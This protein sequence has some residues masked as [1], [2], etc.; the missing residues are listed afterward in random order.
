MS[1]PF[2]NFAVISGPDWT[3]VGTAVGTIA[4]AAM[5]FL[6][7]VTTIAITV[8]DR[9]RAE[10]R[11]EKERR[12]QQ[13][14][15]QLARAY[16][17]AFESSQVIGSSAG[18]LPSDS[19][20][21]VYAAKVMNGS[22][23]PIWNVVCMI[24]TDHPS[25]A[26]APLHTKLAARVGKFVDVGLGSAASAEQFIPFANGNTYRIK[27]LRSGHQGAFIW[28]FDIERYFNP[29]FSARFTDD[30]DRHW[31]IGSDLHLTDIESRD[32]W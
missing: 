23:R 17:V 26:S 12:Q 16:A 14:R 22:D 9:R 21:T 32:D 15:E 1:Q 2:V 25:F 4:L 30:L 13:N 18:V 3:S 10:A 20:D 8:Q 5:T 24:E 29:R 6:A 27:V 28:P 7:V 31:E 11:I 19:P